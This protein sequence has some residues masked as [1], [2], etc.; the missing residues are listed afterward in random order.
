MTTPDLMLAG[1]FASP[2][3]QEW[4]AEVLKALNRRRPPGSELTLE[5][6]MARL[7]TVT[8]DGLSIAPLYTRTDAH[9]IGYPG[10]M[11][12][13]R[14]A[15]AP[16]SA[17]PWI[18]EQ[19]HEDPDATR[20]N[21]H[22]L[23]DLQCGA[24]GVWL[25][26]DADAI[27]PDDL[28]V[29]LAGVVPEAV[30]LSVSSVTRQEAAAEALLS[31]LAG[32]EAGATGSLGIDPLG[33]AAVTGEPVDLTKLAA[34]IGRA[35]DG[36]RALSV[37]VTP[38]DDAGAGDVQQVGYAIATGLAYV[39]A[40]EEQGVSPDRAFASIRFRVAATADQF[41]T[42]CRLRA[43]RRAWARVG[44][45]L[46]VPEAA[47]GAVQHAVT[48]RRILTRD[49]PWVNL[50]R[51][52]ISSFAAAVGGAEIITTLP[53]DTACGLPTPFSRRIARNIQ[54]LAAEETHLGA[55][56][57]PA[58]GSWYVENLTDQIAGNAWTLMQAIEAA[59]G[60]ARSLA[61]G[62]VA[63]QIAEVAAARA[64]L[65]ATRKLPLTGVSMF[66]KP[67][68][69]PLDDV[70]PRPPRPPYHGLPVRRDAAPFEALRDR[71]RAYAAAHAG[72][73]PAVLLACLGEQRDYGARQGF[74]SALLGVAGLNVVEIPGP[75]PA[76]L[77]LAATDHRVVILAS[78]AKV[79]AEQGVACAQALKDAGVAWVAIAGRRSEI[80][81]EAADSLIDQEIYDSMDVVALLSGLLDR[82]GV[83]K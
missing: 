81:S 5:Q 28:G 34:W 53:H 58:G 12:F 73:P 46:A 39:R 77:A 70:V 65:I 18:V 36:V 82:L 8:V 7:T 26:V 50:L 11:P 45:V 67:D 15:Q 22:V 60:M 43:L 63:A 57:D 9:P 41:G 78:S 49:D 21:L 79:Y 80:G 56:T 13:T 16:G 10:Q 20:T 74:T 44:E 35:P 83:A 23:D 6:A 59:G 62:T 27:V 75:S 72:A 32:H 48:S 68:E 52:T 19:L 40:L 37:D 64:A 25:R 24:R 33:A 38:Y 4:D 31:C 71:S 2:T 69:T 61:D 42:I 1:E 54:L 30:D 17:S 3:E 76:E 29:A 66:P 51:A 47:R 14:G 55:V